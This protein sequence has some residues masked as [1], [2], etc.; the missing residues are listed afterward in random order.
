M[1]AMLVTQLGILVLRCAVQSCWVREY[2]GLEAER[3]AGNE[4]RRRRMARVQEESMARI[5]EMKIGDEKMKKN[6]E[7][8]GRNDFDP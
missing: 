7:Y 4:K 3:E 2:E 5:A 8:E 1:M 6:L